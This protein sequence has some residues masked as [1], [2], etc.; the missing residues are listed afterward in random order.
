VDLHE[1]QIADVV[2]CFHESNNVN[3]T[4][5]TAFFQDNLQLN[6]MVD[7]LVAVVVVVCSAVVCNTDGGGGVQCG[8]MLKPFL[9]QLQM[10]FTKALNDTSRAVRLRAADALS[11]LVT[12]HGRVDPLF[13]ELLKAAKDADDTAVR[14]VYDY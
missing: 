12:I 8:A 11:H 4:I 2:I 13:T 6:Q 3:N 1:C 7:I 10:T 9:P 14:S 5:L